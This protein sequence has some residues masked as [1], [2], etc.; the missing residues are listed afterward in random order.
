MLLKVCTLYFI[1][2]HLTLLE[3]ALCRF[4]H[5]L[6]R[7]SALSAFEAEPGNMKALQSTNKKY[8][9]PEIFFTVRSIGIP[10]MTFSTNPHMS[11]TLSS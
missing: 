3:R 1:Y 8:T 6:P 2:M 7:P 11:N 4:V 10:I 5:K 9:S